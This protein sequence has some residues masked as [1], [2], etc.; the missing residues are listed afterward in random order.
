MNF[1]EEWNDAIFYDHWIAHD[2]CDIIDPRRIVAAP[3]TGLLF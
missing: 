3:K 2:I 1:P